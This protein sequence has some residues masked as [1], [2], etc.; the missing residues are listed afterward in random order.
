MENN[1]TY[2]K[3]PIRRFIAG[4]YTKQ[5][6]K[7][8]LELLRDREKDAIIDQHMSEVWDRLQ[9]SPEPGVFEYNYD[10]EQGGELLKRIEKPSSYRKYF[11]SG[12]V[13]ASV[14]LFITLGIIGYTYFNTAHITELQYT[15]VST[16]HGET[17]GIIL[18]DGTVTIL[19]SCSHLSY[20][21]K[22]EGNE[23][24]IKLEG[25][26]YFHV[27]KNEAKPF[28]IATQNF[29]IRILGTV[30][31]IKAY[32]EDKIQSVNV[33]S[34]KVQVDM[35]DG[36]ARLLANEQFEIN[37]STNSYTKNESVYKDISVWRSGTLRFN[38]TPIGDVAKQLERVYNCRI[39]FEQGQIFENIISGEHD[40][41][42]LKEV[43]ASIRL[44]SGIKWK[45]SQS[46]DTITLYK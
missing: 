39:I 16:G 7:Q 26:A 36:M 25:E 30:F 1:K 29:N 40:N 13:A 27:T 21:E 22:F 41:E 9:S 2:R 14:T 19:N 43:L 4:T 15:E 33:E 6:A 24:H 38:K 34:G 23:R 37:T 44:A 31:N 42:S 28:T 20:P 46:G 10:F 12:L 45:V 18:P 17:K 5:E 32:R 35:P 11:K 8:V 3:N